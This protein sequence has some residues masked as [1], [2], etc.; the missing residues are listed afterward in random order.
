MRKALHFLRHSKL[1]IPTI[2]LHGGIMNNYLNKHTHLNISNSNVSF[3]GIYRRNSPEHLSHIPR[4]SDRMRE[5]TSAIVATVVEI[6]E[7]KLQEWALTEWAMRDRFC[8]LQVQQHRLRF[9]D[10]WL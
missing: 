3:L 7:Q 2:L 9:R 5:W 1:Y 10:F 4:R 6:G 8:P